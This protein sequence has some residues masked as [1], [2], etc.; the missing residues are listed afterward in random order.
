MNKKNNTVLYR[1]IHRQNFT[2]A[3]LL[4]L[5]V[6]NEAQARWWS[7]CVDC[8]CD[9]LRTVPLPSMLYTY[10]AH[11]APLIVSRNIARFIV[12]SY[13][14]IFRYNTCTELWRQLNK[15]WRL[16]KV[17]CD[18]FAYL[19]ST[20][21][22]WWDFNW[23]IT[24]TADILVSNSFCFLQVFGIVEHQI[25]CFVKVCAY[26]ISSDWRWLD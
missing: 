19:W 8:T 3:V 7:R 11:M 24:V 21:F 4:S 25:I 20:W 18:L 13:S 9:D 1:D 15:M 22:T 6:D 2:T 5:R 17:T 14:L 23:Q 10:R 16:E 26:Q 12:S